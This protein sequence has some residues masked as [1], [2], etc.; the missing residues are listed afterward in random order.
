MLI[1]EQIIKIFLFAHTD[2]PEPQINRWV[3]QMRLQQ[4]R[5]EQD[6]LWKE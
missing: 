6:P 3:E 1:D 5:A 2:M 4:S